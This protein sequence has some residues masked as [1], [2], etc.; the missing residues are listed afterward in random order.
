MHLFSPAL[1][2]M[3]KIFFLIETNYLK[4]SKG[5]IIVLSLGT[6]NIF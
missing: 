2:G 6:R 1:A 5:N 4:I 3:E